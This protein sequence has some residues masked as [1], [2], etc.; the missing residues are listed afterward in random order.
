MLLFNPFSKFANINL[1][2]LIRSCGFG[3]WTYL[4]LCPLGRWQALYCVLLIGALSRHLVVHC[5]PLTHDE[6]KTA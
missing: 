6:C 2:F 4:R 5:C 3:C 1:R